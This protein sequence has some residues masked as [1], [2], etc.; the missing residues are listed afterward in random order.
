MEGGIIHPLSHKV[1]E[2]SARIAFFDGAAAQK[3]NVRQVNSLFRAPFV[4]QIL[5]VEQ[6]RYSAYVI[7]DDTTRHFFFPKKTLLPAWRVDS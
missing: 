1:F 7:F 2:F 6:L 4:S 3:I 5:N